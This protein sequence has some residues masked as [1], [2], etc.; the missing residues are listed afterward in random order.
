MTVPSSSICLLTKT[1]ETKSER[2]KC[3]AVGNSSPRGLRIVGWLTPLTEE[4]FDEV[5]TK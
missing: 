1:T 5:P 3:F 4:C 2:C